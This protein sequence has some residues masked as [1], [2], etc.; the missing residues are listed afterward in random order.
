MAASPL[1]S[2][3]ERPPDDSRAPLLCAR[4]G[5]M[6]RDTGRSS[7]SSVSPAAM[8]DAPP[9]H[10]DPRLLSDLIAVIYIGFIAA[11]ASAL[12]AIYVLFPELGALSWDVFG[13]PR[14]RWAAAPL[15]LAVTPALTGT[16][17]TVVTR[18]LPYGFVSVMLIG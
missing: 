1:R 2:A 18:T 11:V 14:G 10:R 12:G 17:G 3:P 9:S 5:A 16:L 13:R 7:T 4:D 8:G 15:M 6:S